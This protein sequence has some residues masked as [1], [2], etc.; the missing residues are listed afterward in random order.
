MSTNGWW[1]VTLGLGLVVAVVAVVL[2]QVFFSRLRR[3]ECAAERIWH[4]GKQVAGNTATIW[5]LGIT[6]ER[7]E[8]L[9]DEA[10]LHQELLGDGAAT[11]GGS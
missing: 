6:S 8:S 7:L 9:A 5:Q 11:A 1:A 3:I 10:A 2:L 4:T